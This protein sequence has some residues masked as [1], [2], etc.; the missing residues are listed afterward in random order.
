MRKIELMVIAVVSIQKKKKK[1]EGSRALCEAYCVALTLLIAMTKAAK[2]PRPSRIDKLLKGIYYN[3]AHPASFGSIQSLYE[4]AKLKSPRKAMRKSDIIGWLQKQDTYTLHKPVIRKFVKRKTITSG[5]DKQWQADLVQIGQISKHNRN[6]KYLLCCICIFSRY[7]MVEPL[8]DKTTKVVVSAFKKIFKREKRQ[9]VKLQTD[10]GMEFLG[11]AAVEMYKSLGIIHFSTS[12]DVKASIVE[13]YQKNL[14]N[15]IYK[16]M[17]ANNTLRYIDNLQNFVSAYNKRKHR[18]VNIAPAN[19]TK[20][21]ES[22]I[23]KHQ[24]GP[25]LKSLA[26][27]HRYKIGDTVRISKYKKAFSR[28]YLPNWSKEIF[29][30]SKEISSRPPTYILEDRS[31]DILKGT[32]YDAELSKVISN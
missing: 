9:P 27:K 10:D 4:A 8:K 29:V 25:Y 11:K 2:S 1:P 3:P 20:K 14:E 21:N 23:Y 7:A 15:T 24:Y 26:K 6:V 28:G 13:R 5:I 16:Y 30:I 32:F 12:S 22:L 18:I 17:T 19:I 31:G